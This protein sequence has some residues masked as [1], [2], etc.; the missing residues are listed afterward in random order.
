[1][2]FEQP[3]EPELP[4]CELIADTGGVSL[5]PFP[6]NY[7][8]RGSPFHVAPVCYL[9]IS[10]RVNQYVRKRFVAMTDKL[11][12]LGIRIHI[13]SVS[14]LAPTQAIFT[15]SGQFPKWVN[16]EAQLRGDTAR[17]GGYKLVVT[18][19]GIVL[20]GADEGGVQHACATL[21]QLIEDGPDVPGMEIEDYPILRY[22]A[23]HLDC[24]GWPPRTTWIK[25]AIDTLASIKINILIL[26]YEAH[27]DYPS[28]PN[29][30]ADGALSAREVQDLDTYA[31]ENG[32]TLVPLLSCVGNAG[33]VLARPEY[34]ALR[35][36]PDS[37][38]ML[39][40]SNPDTLEFLVAQLS[41]LLPIH[42]GKMFHVGGDG[43]FLLGANATT[44]ARA[45]ELGGLDAVY[46]DHVGSITRF[47]CSNGVQPLV[48]DDMLRQMSDEQ[49]KWLPPDVTIVFWLPEGLAPELAQDVLAH[50]ERYKVLGR[51][52]WG[53][54][55]LS[56]SEH[57]QSFD[58]IDAW[59]EIGE[60]NYITGFMASIRTRDFAK[61]AML[62]PPEAFWARIF[63]AADRAW[64]GKQTIVRE[65]FPQRFVTRFF[66]LKN[67]ETQSRMWA[68]F[69]HAIGNNPLMAHTFFSAE[70]PHVPKNQETAQFLASWNA[71]Q[72]FM[73]IFL[74]VENDVRGNFVN[75]QNGTAD[76]LLAGHLRWQTQE[77]KAR[78][79]VLISQFS[80]IAENIS[81]EWAVHEFI[82]SSVAY[83]LR[84]LDEMEPLLAAFPLPAEELREPLG[85]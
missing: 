85:I 34:A 38:R 66:G 82:E 30:A 42:S 81:G 68:G 28:M 16:F 77:L 33:H 63:Y 19:D 12:A 8:P 46:L 69:V 48:F 31:R 45:E 13:Y 62:P 55:V 84:R 32:V 56:P 70:A 24:K 74:E 64:S 60:M 23:V 59:A 15:D 5:L 26:E 71:I 76:S 41:D 61:S 3:H 39:C 9:Y 1:M 58:N 57:F 52:A 79:T 7:T 10:S 72:A 75:I 44:Q 35:E 78:A 20:H 17:A 40:I 80:Q 50:L 4:S 54:A 14:Q 67:L 37:A 22:R 6:R 47:L 51:Q 36:H 11:P 29:W 2:E 49:I 43:T 18:Q 83:T 53:S 65:L 21:H 25:K 73:R 27:F